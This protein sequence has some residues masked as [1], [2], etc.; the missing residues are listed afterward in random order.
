[1]DLLKSEMEEQPRL[2]ARVPDLN[3]ETLENI[4]RTMKLRGI[5]SV[6]FVGRGS[7][8]SACVYGEY[9][10]NICAKL[11]ASC[12]SMSP[13]SIYESEV[14]FPPRTMVIGISQSGKAEDVVQVLDCAL[15]HGAMA[16]AVTNTPNSPITRV[17]TDLQEREAERGPSEKPARRD[18]F[19]LDCGVG[20]E[21]GLAATKTLTAAMLLLAALCAKVSSGGELLAQIDRLPEKI[22]DIL[23]DVPEALEEIAPR[24]RFLRRVLVLGR[25]MNYAA[26]LDGAHK[27]RVNCGL[28]ADG[29]AISDF[30]HGAIAELSP[31]MLAIVL[32][33]SGPI[34]R[35]AEWVLKPLTEA[36]VETL[37]LTDSEDMEEEDIRKEEGCRLPAHTVRIPDCGGD[38]LSPILFEVALQCVMLEMA[39]I[40]GI[41]PDS[42][43]KIKKVTVTK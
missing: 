24:W 11:P 31:D 6:C 1:M 36:G 28:H 40:R 2:L 27:L 29:C 21:N 3:A 38:L 14:V 25:G 35:D 37:V 42:S 10:F 20:E 18:F 19:V 43:A 7:S 22:E 34:L 26:A 33:S 13:V 15:R 32:A 23:D 12:F 17:L 4:V 16:V 41:D 5:D 30:S 8:R 39:K 9:L